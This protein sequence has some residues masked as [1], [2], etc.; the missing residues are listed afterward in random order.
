MNRTGRRSAFRKDFKNGGGFETING[1]PLTP[2]RERFTDELR[3]GDEYIDAFSEYVKKEREKRS[4]TQR[5]LAWVLRLGHA[6]VS[7]I[8]R[9]GMT[10]NPKAYTVYKLRTFFE[11]TAKMNWGKLR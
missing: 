8:E 3:T 11:Q 1:V 5:E 7:Q 2:L 9:T 4:M 6:T 10:R